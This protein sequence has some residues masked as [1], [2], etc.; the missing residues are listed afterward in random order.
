MVENESSLMSSVV[1][2]S[3]KNIDL[4]SQISPTNL[5]NGIIDG[6][7]GVL[8]LAP[9]PTDIAIIIKNI[10]TTKTNDIHAVQILNIVSQTLGN[11][12]LGL[13]IELYNSK[14]DPYWHNLMNYQ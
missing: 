10:P 1:S 13:A 14:N 9:S 2:W 7:N 6:D 3:N 8:T 11:R 5:Y 12:T 4:G